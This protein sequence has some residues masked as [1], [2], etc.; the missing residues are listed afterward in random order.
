M[1][2]SITGAIITTCKGMA[3]IFKSKEEA[4]YFYKQIKLLYI[5]N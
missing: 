2:S 1:A 3:H 5:K 4:I